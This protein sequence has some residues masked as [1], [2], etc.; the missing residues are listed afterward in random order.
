MKSRFGP[1]YSSPKGYTVWLGESGYAHSFG[2]DSWS[3]AEKVGEPDPPVLLA[4][5]D[6]S[7]GRLSSLSDIGL[8]ELPLVSRIYSNAWLYRQDFRLLKVGNVFEVL[9][10]YAGPVELLEGEERF[11]TPIPEKSIRLKKMGSLEYP[12]DEFTYETGCEMFLGSSCFFRLLGP[13]L[14]LQEP[15][16]LMCIGCQ[17][18]MNYLAG[19]GYELYKEPEG[20][21]ENRPFFIGETALYFFICKRCLI[22]SVISQ[23]S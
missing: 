10:R 20:F 8:R 12:V 3:L 23:P 6:L 15:E 19:I 13:P 2:G 5:F 16:D 21:F 17:H 1:D 9:S 18:K 7:D 11:Q 22:Q 4:K 14:W